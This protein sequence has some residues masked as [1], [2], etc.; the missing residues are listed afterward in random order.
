MK[1]I[2]SFLVIVIILFSCQNTK[3]LIKIQNTKKLNTIDFSYLPYNLPQTQ[4][5]I[6]VNIRRITYVKGPFEEY[7]IKYLG[8]NIKTIKNSL[9]KWEILDAEISSNPIIDTNNTYIVSFNDNFV[10]PFNFS[11]EYFPISFNCKNNE[12]KTNENSFLNEEQKN[13]NK[14]TNRIFL[15]AKPYKTVYDTSFIEKEIDTFKIQMPILKS[16]ISRKTNDEQAKEI[17]D[18]LNTLKEDRYLLIVGQSDKII[19]TTELLSNM[20][21]QINEYEQQYIRAF[22]GYT[23]TTEYTYIFTYTP[24]E[25]ETNIITPLFKFSTENGILANDASIGTDVYLKISTNSVY[26]NNQKLYSS[27]VNAL[28][29]KKKFNLLPYR[30]PQKSN[31]SI[32]Y[33]NSKIINKQIDIAQFGALAYLKTEVLF[34]KNTNIIFNPEYGS[35][36]YIEVRK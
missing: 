2:S 21:T 6:K 22:I 12:I 7:T 25:S 33:Q 8:S 17:A 26:I 36:K 18:K 16:N 20:L 10:L 34:D 32:I 30:V 31:I 29:Q 3:N 19:S 9:T 15:G 4:I 27:Y 28:N 24:L 11:D 5:I 35:I 14:D 13:K 23:D 1:R